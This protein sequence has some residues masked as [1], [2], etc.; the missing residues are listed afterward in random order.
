VFAG[1]A[2]LAWMLHVRS[3]AEE[4]GVRFVLHA[5]NGPLQALLQRSGLGDD[6]SVARWPVRA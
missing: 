5:G 4:H 1:S 6:L 2:V 3:L